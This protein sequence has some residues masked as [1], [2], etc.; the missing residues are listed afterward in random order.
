[1]VCMV[2]HDISIKFVLTSTLSSPRSTCSCRTKF[3][4]QSPRSRGCRGHMPHPTKRAPSL[5]SGSWHF[6][7]L[8]QTPDRPLEY[9]D[10]VGTFRTITWSRPNT[11]ACIQHASILDTNFLQRKQCTHGF[12]F[13]SS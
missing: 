1:M 4:T 2:S 10:S 9:S 8:T 11:S 12:N 6:N 7:S 5:M 13:Q 3:Q